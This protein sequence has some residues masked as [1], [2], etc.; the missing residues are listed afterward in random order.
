MG[1]LAADFN[2]DVDYYHPDLRAKY[3]IGDPDPY[4]RNATEKTAPDT[5]TPDIQWPPDFAKFQQRTAAW[6][7]DP[8]RS[9]LPKGW[10]ERVDHPLSWTASELREEEYVIEFSP[11]DVVEIE[12]GLA[13]CKG[14]DFPFQTP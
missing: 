9:Q 13:D 14:T 6:P 10:P 12:H 3:H 1:S 7:D 5:L 11:A 8:R 2:P 4:P